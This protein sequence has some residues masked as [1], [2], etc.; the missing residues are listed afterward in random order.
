MVIWIIPLPA[1][2]IEVGPNT[3]MTKIRFAH[4]PK[5]TLINYHAV[6]KQVLMH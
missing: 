3:G 2:T 4:I 5:W 1:M 6:L